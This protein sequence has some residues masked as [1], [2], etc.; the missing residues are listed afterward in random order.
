MTGVRNLQSGELI[1]LRSGHGRAGDLP[2]RPCPFARR[3]C[4]AR[5]RRRSAQ[6]RPV[7]ARRAAE[8]A[9]A[10]RC[11]AIRCGTACRARP[12]RERA[13]LAAFAAVSLAVHG[14][15]LM[16]FWREPTPLASIGVEVISVEIVVGAT[17]PA[18]IAATP[19][20]QQVHAAAAPRPRRPTPTRRT[21]RQPRSRR[22]SRSPREE[23]APEQKPSSRKPQEAKPEEP[24][25]ETAAAPESPRRPSRSRPSRWSRPRRP[26]P[27]PQSRRRRRRRRPNDA[28]A[29]TGG[30]AGREDGRAKPVQAAP[31]KPVKDTK[32]AKEPR[33]IAAPTRETR[34]AGGEGFDALDRGE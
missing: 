12:T 19:G 5:S 22:R 3:D 13:R 9:G 15:L 25:F 20:E 7:P 28:A 6:C 33:R 2:A 18:G 8:R 26:T 4:A 14:G 11:A 27:R 30:K 34:R 24:K 16:A 31:P 21:R 10:G 1:A 17:A 23:T 29:A 32:P